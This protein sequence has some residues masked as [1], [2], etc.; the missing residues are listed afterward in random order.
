MEYK[1]ITTRS[2]LK[3]ITFEDRT[4]HGDYTL[5]PYEKCEFGCKY[6]DSPGETIF[7]KNNVEE[8]VEKELKNK[9]GRIIIGS[10]YDPYQKAESLFKKTR[11]V[12]KIIKKTDSPCHILTKSDLIL[13]D[14]DIIA[15]MKNCLVTISIT[16]L[17][18][19]IQ[20]LF[21]NKIPTSE[22]RLETVKKIAERG[23]KTGVAVIPFLPFIVEDEIEEI[24]K[25][26][27]KHK[28]HY[29]LYKPLEL[30][31]DQKKVFLDVLK[32]SFPSLVKKYESLYNTSYLP[33]PEY[34]REISKKFEKTC[35][36]NNLK[37]CIKN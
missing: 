31:G 10:V 14:I 6:C 23:V 4:F 9:Q 36:K 26:A 32:K 16:S 3:K 37:T 28:A 7:I 29:L 5:D 2:V 17:K 35:R 11:K 33:D 25:S 20:K 24:V 15:D 22:T 18:E 13:R 21:E 27:K 1:P 12:L 30:K 8:I 34:S 19:K